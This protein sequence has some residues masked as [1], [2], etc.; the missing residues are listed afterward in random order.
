MAKLPDMSK[1]TV[2]ALTFALA[3]LVVAALVVPTCRRSSA[4][5]TV[6]VVDTAS[7][8]TVAP[9][10]KMDRLR[11]N[12]KKVDKIERHMPTQRYHLD[13]DVTKN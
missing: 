12:A 1:A 2:A 7:V 4:P 5:A 8:D 9:R 11:K 13:E 3:L 10:S 6:V